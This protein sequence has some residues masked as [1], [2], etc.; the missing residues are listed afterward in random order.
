MPKVESISLKTLS[1]SID[2]AVAL[3]ERR[4]GI[5]TDGPNLALGWT[6]YGRI[7]REA[8]VDIDSAFQTA[9]AITKAAKVR[10]IQADPT[11]TRVGKNILIGFVERAAAPKLIGR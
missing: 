1:S 10:G 5:K 11:V 4:R 2:R 8:A 3:A 9:A 7:L 6:I